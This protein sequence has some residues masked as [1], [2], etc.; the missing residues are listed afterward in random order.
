MELS[1]NTLGR[2]LKVTQFSSHVRIVCESGRPVRLSSQLGPNGSRVDVFIQP[3]SSGTLK[4][5]D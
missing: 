2:I 3:E 5:T 4:N 1:I